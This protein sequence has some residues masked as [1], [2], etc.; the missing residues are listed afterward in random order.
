MKNIVKHM[1]STQREPLPGKKQIKNAAGGF[2][3]QVDDWT[4]LERFLILGTEGG[5][6]YASERKITRE[7]AQCVE[8]LLKENGP[9][10]V[11]TIVAVSTEGRAP[12]NDAAVF[13]LAMALKLGD[14][15]TRRVAQVAVP[16]VCRTGTHLF[17]LAEAVKAFG[18]WGRG[19][20]AAFAGWYNGLT[21]DHLALQAIKYQQRDGWSHRDIL[22]KIHVQPGADRAGVLHWMVK[23]W[24]SVGELPHPDKVLA[25]IW[26]F[27]KA[28]TAKG[29]ELVRLI[30]DYKLP[31]ECV[32]NEQKGDPKVWEAMLPS[33]GITALIRNLGKMT[34]VGLLKPLSATTRFVREQLENE[35]L[36]KK[37]RVHPMTILQAQRVYVQGHGDKGSLVWT[38]EQGVV[39]ALNAG[40]YLAFKTVEPTGKRTLLAMDVSGSMDGGVIAGMTGMTPR[41]ASAAMALVT[42]N[43]EKD[44]AFIGFTSGGFGMSRSRGDESGVTALK[45]SPKQ[46]LDDVVRYMQGL[47]MGGTDCALPMRWALANKI[48]V[49]TFCVY[50]DNETWAGNVQPVTALRDYRQKMGIPSKLIVVGMTATDCSIADPTDGGM[51]D[52]TGFDT[53]A[54]AVMADFARD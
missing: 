52:V 37:G 17:H 54:P 38:P 43:V 50:T 31:H 29:E 53:A 21:P 11:N 7:N 2:V 24:D 40:F 41:V 48:E 15:D 23:G 47:P 42:A 22:R 49:D 10:V 12:K 30:R 25:K 46:R 1:Q 3:F 20:Q 36:L 18:G 27:E 9:Q 28:K 35:E 34:K 19:T 16:K 32:P 45:I 39:D 8:R 14:A 6:Y 26:A 44:H 4:R 5:T 51:L 33:M 13:A